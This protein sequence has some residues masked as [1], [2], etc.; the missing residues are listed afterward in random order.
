MEK[1]ATII[2]MSW[3]I[4]IPKDPDPA[5]KL[6]EDA[7][8]EACRR[9]VLMFCSSPDGGQFVNI[10]DY[11]SAVQRDKMFRIGA[12]HDYGSASESTDR[13]VDF[14]LPGVN[15]NT[16]TATPATGSSVATA[17]AAGLA[18]TIIYCFKISALAAKTQTQ[19]MSSDDLLRRNNREQRLQKI[20]NHAEMKNAFNSIGTV[21]PSRFIQVWEVLDTVVEKL[22]SSQSEEHK[23]AKVE[24]IN[25]LCTKM[26]WA[27]GRV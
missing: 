4:P 1:N 14:I 18:A 23:D 13:G 21:T 16:N 3:T 20:F 9:N 24:A 6:F 7:V 19:T 10:L 27:P 26:M 17:L 15:V 8:R 2:S 25:D 12:A 5:Q 11:P 22:E